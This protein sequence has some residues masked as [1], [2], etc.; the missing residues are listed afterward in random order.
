MVFKAQSPA[1][2]AEEYLIDSIW[3]ERFPPGS[4]LPAERELSEMIG[5][6]RTTLRE[7]LQRLA[8]DGWLTIRHGKPTQVNDIWQTS[9]LNILETLARLDGDKFPQL[10]DQLLSARTNISAIFIRSALKRNPK[11]VLEIIERR[12]SVDENSAQFVEYDYYFYHELALAS[13]NMIYVLVL[14]GFKNLYQK[15]GAF[16]FDLPQARQLA[17]DFY[18]GLEHF[19][20]AD[21]H[22]S[23]HQYV[24]D[25]GKQSAQLW[26]LVKSQLPES[27][28]D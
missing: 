4:I 8:R 19:I 5:V 1:G 20:A 21:K 14:N 26:G 28:N 9:G 24:R 15:L 3:N 10:I 13:D 12:P 17:L 2:V 11:K 6:T 18:L 27:F 7:V 25:Y 16:Y 22:N 23:V